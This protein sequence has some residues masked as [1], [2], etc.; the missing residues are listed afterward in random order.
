M[1]VVTHRIA[2]SFDRAGLADH[3][4]IFGMRANPEPDISVIRF[5]GHRPIV[6]TDARRPESPNFLKVKRG[7]F[8]IGLQ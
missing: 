5:N 7:M 3:F 1:D 4:V 8:G 2:A 6:K